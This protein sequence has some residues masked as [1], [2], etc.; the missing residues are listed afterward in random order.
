MA[1]KGGELF[2][3]LVGWGG[4][5]FS[6][7]CT[8]ALPIVTAFLIINIALGILTRAAPQLNLFCLGFPITL[9]VGFIMLALTVRYLAVP[10]DLLFAEAFTV[11]REM[12]SALPKI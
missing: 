6:A 11:M 3:Q 4:R 10:L 7:S 2:R 1:P 12:T 8:P 5:I 9:S